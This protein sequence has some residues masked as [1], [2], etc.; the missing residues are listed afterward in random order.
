MSFGF[1]GFDPDSMPKDF[2][3]EVITGLG[4]L[5]QTVFLQFEAAMLPFVPSNVKVQ[6]WIPQQDL[7]GKKILQHLP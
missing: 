6:P 3:R 4:R 7:L 5:E 2:M 1:T